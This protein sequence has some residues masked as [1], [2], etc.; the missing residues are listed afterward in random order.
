MDTDLLHRCGRDRDI[1]TQALGEIVKI[2]TRLLAGI[3][4]MLRRIEKRL[5]V[6]TNEYNE[7]R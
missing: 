6:K 5:E 2:Q 3:L 1:G 4:L 7:N